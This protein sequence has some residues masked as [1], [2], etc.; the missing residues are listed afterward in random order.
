MYRIF[1]THEQAA[2]F[3]AHL[4][5]DFIS[6]RPAGVLGLATGGTM[7]P[8]YAHLI[9]LIK[10]HNTSLEQLTT[11]NLDEYVGLSRTHPQSYYHY[12]Q[13]HLFAHLPSCPDSIN[14]PNGCA[15]DLEQECRRY[16]AAIRSH[17]GLDLQL[18]GV[19]SNG[20]IGFNEPHTAFNSITHVVE[21][22]E[23]TRLDNGRFFDNFDEVPTQAITMGIQDIMQAKQIVLV[24]TG[25]HKAHTVLDFFNSAVCES[26]PASCLK[27]H[28]NF[29]LVMD[30]AAAQLVSAETLKKLA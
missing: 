26:M 13:E 5:Q 17:G 1:N 12:M 18:L 21:L 23:Q 19:G 11:F 10:Q 22:S 4:L 28:P 20:H 29:L 2:Q 7:E 15:T 6:Q 27:N 9:E 3:T 14:L 8:V 16:T 30:Q 25:A 24:V